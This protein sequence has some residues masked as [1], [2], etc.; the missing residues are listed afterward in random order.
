MIRLVK[1]QK[2][3]DLKIVCKLN[4]F[5]IVLDKKFNLIMAT[6]LAETSK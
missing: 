6:I 3:K 2:F 5:K 4:V 1:I